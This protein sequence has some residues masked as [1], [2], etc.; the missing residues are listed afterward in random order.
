[1]A[2]VAAAVAAVQCLA[3]E[4][5]IRM[6]VLVTI[7]VAIERYVGSLP[8]VSTE[9]ICSTASTIQERGPKVRNTKLMH[10]SASRQ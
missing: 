7:V 8:R 2:A 5:L 4:E 10:S 9:R 6:I 3:S 1:V